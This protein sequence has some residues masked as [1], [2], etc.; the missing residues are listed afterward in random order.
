MRRV[1]RL[2]GLTPVT[3]LIVMVALAGCEET[4]T[5]VEPPP[6]KVSVAQPLVQE[7]ID[8]L[9]MT[10]STVASG[11]VDV[12][13]RVSGELQ[14]MH[15]QPGTDVE[16]GDLLFVIDP[17]EYQAALQGAAAELGAAEAQV[18]RARIEFQRAK[19]LYAKKAGSESDV[20]KW[21]GE[22]EVATAE[23]QRAQA[24][25]DRAQLD[26]DYTQ[27]IA[28]I[29]GRVGRNRV[30]IGNLVGEGEAT[31]LTEITDF[32][33]MYAY[34]NLNERDFLRLSTAY[35]KRVKEKGLDPAVDPD[36]K[37]GIP[38]F[39]GLANEEGYP[40]TGIADFAESG[41]DP[42]T[43]TLQLRGVFENSGSP[44]AVTSGLFARIRLPVDKRADMLLVSER[45][46]GADQS[47]RFLLIAN[48]N[49]VIEK[50]SIRQGQLTDGMRVIEEG[51]ESGE[52]V[53][54]KGLQRA[55]PGGKV[56][57]EKT[58]MSKLTVSAMRAVASGQNQ[59]SPARENA[60]RASDVGRE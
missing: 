34:F 59:G 2:A 18:R 45:A 54:V 32:D 55:R 48:S 37:A 12:P 49:N 30:D 57:P 58:D 46:I 47:G 25:R 24:K 11:R 19:N 35:R 60:P 28:P 22:L 26:L 52:W 5:Y 17:R 31:V 44:P 43:G 15:F 21:R 41:L 51:L 50:R 53:V 10:G 33:P 40:H 36:R 9:E 27:V 1:S 7:I 3:A 4:N 23:I 6:P 8:Y 29:E 39:L 56:E 16:A 20:V 14:S 13:A 38:V 42:N